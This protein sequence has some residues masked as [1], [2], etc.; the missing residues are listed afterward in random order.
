[1][2]RGGWC[3]W[4]VRPARRAVE[5][6]TR[7]TEMAVSV[8]LF[9][10]ALGVAALLAVPGICAGAEDNPAAAGFKLG[11]S[12]PRAVAVADATMKAMGG[13]A[14]WDQTRYLTWKFF[15]TRLHVWDKWTGDARIEY[16]QRGG[17]EHVII[18]M[19]IKSQKGRAWQGGVEV[20][21]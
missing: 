6:M 8:A 9:V 2:I 18:L 16:D 20:K 10:A 21:E 13:R 3:R 14:A 5:P 12:D 17:G 4:Y 1:M 15:G 11:A 19:N 7:R